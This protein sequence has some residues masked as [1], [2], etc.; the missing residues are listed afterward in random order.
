MLSSVAITVAVLLHFAHCALASSLSQDV[1]YNAILTV[2]RWFNSEYE[3]TGYELV[4]IECRIT[5]FF[6]SEKIREL[7]T[8]D[9]L[10]QC[11][12]GIELVT[13]AD[14]AD[15]CARVLAV[16]GDF[17]QLY[18]GLLKFHKRSPTALISLHKFFVRTLVALQ[19]PNNRSGQDAKLRAFTSEIARIPDM[20]GRRDLIPYVKPG[21]RSKFDLITILAAKAKWNPLLFAQ[22]LPM[23]IDQLITYCDGKNRCYD[24]AAE[25]VGLLIEMDF[26]KGVKYCTVIFTKLLTF[27]HRN[28]MLKD[29]AIFEIVHPESDVAEF[30]LDALLDLWGAGSIQWHAGE[31]VLEDPNNEEAAAGPGNKAAPAEFC[32]KN[33][34]LLARRPARVVW[35][36]YE[37]YYCNPL[38]LASAIKKF[39]ALDPKLI[40]LHYYFCKKGRIAMFSSGETLQSYFDIL[41]EENLI[42]L[43]KY[44]SEETDCEIAASIDA[45]LH[46]MAQ[47]CQN[48]LYQWAK[49]YLEDHRPAIDHAYYAG[50]P[51]FYDTAGKICDRLVGAQGS[52]T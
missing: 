19:R 34:P 32:Y 18:S 40:Y 20:L 17:P 26:V 38:M 14:V 33:R 24:L 48:R 36:L 5:E 16:L 12:R 31:A 10:A 3:C 15:A 49:M 41:S 43:L 29:A 11:R 1:D 8:D 39:N 13:F 27:A 30:L 45:L 50:S 52:R 42:W 44:F 21:P 25:V 51:S 46:G 9:E 35:L 6:G 23:F 22:G 47:G 7:V 28:F 4:E 2:E 37:K